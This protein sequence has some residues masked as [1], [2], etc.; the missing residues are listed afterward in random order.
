MFNTH[1]DKWINVTQNFPCQ[2]S[3]PFLHKYTCTYLRPVKSVILSVDG[4]IPILNLTLFPESWTWTSINA[5]MDAGKDGHRVGWWTYPPN[6]LY[7]GPHKNFKLGQQ[8]LKN[9][10]KIC[11]DFM[12]RKK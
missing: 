8:N 1:T 5:P 12:K 2:I 7:T 10:K 3:S 9:C 4:C 6:E 11:Q